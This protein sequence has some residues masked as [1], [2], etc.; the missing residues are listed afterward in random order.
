MKPLSGTGQI[1]WNNYYRYDDIVSWLTATA[2]A[3]DDV[4]L[5]S[6]GRTYEG[7][8]MYMLQIAKAGSGMPNVMIDAGKTE[9]V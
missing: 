4:T 9:K 8:T 1:D 7:R 6:I 3:D 2:N 5:A